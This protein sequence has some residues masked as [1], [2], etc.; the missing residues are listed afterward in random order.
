M[1]DVIIIGGGAAGLMTAK[2]LSAHHK[3]ILLLEAKDRLGGR[4]CSV[5]NFSFPAEGGAEFIHGN[6]KTT[7]SL[8]KEAHLNK[9]KIKGTFCRIEKGKWYADDHLVPGWELLIRRMKDCKKDISIHDFLDTSFKEKKFDSLKK[10]FTKYIEGYDAANPVNT[11]VFAIRTEMEEEDK[12]Q[13]RPAHGY[14][15]LIDYLKEACL[16]NGAIIKINEPVIKLS[17]NK[18]IEVSTSQKKYFCKKVICAVPLGVLQSTR[19]KSAL[20]IFRI[21]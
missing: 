10:Y 5:N 4:I 18:N 11:S 21:F 20:L 7:F 17:R 12:P 19:S 16:K 13:Y 2:I 3:K 1:Y 15:S 14:Y 8:L 9:E 6:L